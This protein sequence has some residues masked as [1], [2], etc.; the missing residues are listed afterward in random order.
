MDSS[1]LNP[2]LQKLP[3]LKHLVDT[4]GDMSVF[5]YA[6]THYSWTR[7]DSALFLERK[8]EFLGIIGSYIS[9]KFDQNMAAT[10]S[11]SLSKN[12]AVSTAEHHG[13]LWHPFFFQSAL[14]RGIVHPDEAIINLC[15]SH[16]SLGNSSYPRGIVF[17]GDG[18][19]APVEYLHLPFFPASK[20][21]SPVFGLW[22]YTKE[23]LLKCAYPKIHTY[24][25]DKII[26]EETY[27]KIGDF[28]KNFALHET[29]LNA[30]Y[31]SE[32]ITLLNNLWW[33]HLFP[34]L[35]VFIPLDA[36]D[37]VREILIIHI[38]KNTAIAQLVTDEK[39]QSMIEQYFD[40]ISCCFERKNKQ[41][42]YLFW[43]LDEQ[44][45][46]HGLWRERDELV[47]TDGDFRVRLEASSLLSCLVAWNIIPSGLL[48]YTILSCYY[49][50][51]CFWGFSQGDYLP[52]I[53][54]AY[55]NIMQNIDWAQMY[56]NEQA[57]ILNEDIVFLHEN[58][59]QISTALDIYR[60]WNG[61][62]IEMLY[63]TQKVTMRKSLEQMTSEILR[64]L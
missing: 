45:N 34:D 31:Y 26:T 64:C 28:L 6:T 33:Q 38:E 29:V 18:I 62:R 8:K 11:A 12:Y 43:Y 25:S 44:N 47:S 15:T 4:Y 58:V 5:D 1:A 16:V 9:W 7:D 60:H 40:G 42:T 32:Q 20:R 61:N 54:R 49:G 53:Q 23:S 39:I 50:L 56:T 59:G 63:L 41:W 51:K 55:K 14:L 13:P 10:V 36:E 21:M 57:A 46:R 24:L 3:Y 30:T 19:N 37:I 17:H 22:N 35:P 52:K 27:E 2:L 48:V